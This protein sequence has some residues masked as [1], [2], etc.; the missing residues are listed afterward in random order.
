MAVLVAGTVFANAEITI[1]EDAPKTVSGSSVASWDTSSVLTT[2]NMN[3]SV[4]FTVDSEL[5]NSNFKGT[6]LS[7]DYD[8][9]QYANNFKAFIGLT[10]AEGT[11]NLITWQNSKQSQSI[12]FENTKNVTFSISHANGGD[13]TLSV[14]GDSD[15][16]NALT[17][18]NRTGL[19]SFSTNGWA[20]NFGG[21]S[22]TSAAM[23]SLYIP[24]SE[25]QVFD[26]LG[27]GYTAN[28]IASSADLTA[29]YNAIP[30]PSAFGLLAG[31]GALALVGA[32]RRRSR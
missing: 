29:Y 7:I 4:V 22:T 26:L 19:G 16:S 10:Y 30:E 24:N 25:S 5:L 13:L 31:L 9:A 21:V 8:F 1:W 15:F 11:L 17:T 12:S 32:R 6:L 28:E 14:Y 23:Y 3:S 18:I 27:A 20:L 2:F